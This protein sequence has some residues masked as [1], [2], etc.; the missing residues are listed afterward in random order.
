MEEK[1]FKFPTAFTI[2]F[3]LIVIVAGLT[4]VMKT[5]HYDFKDDK[6]TIV[7]AA[8]I[9]SHGTDGLTPVAGTYTELPGNPQ[10]I[11]DI[12]L[13]PIN[14]L[15]DAIDVAGFILVIG[16]FLAVAMS[17]GA[18]DTWIVS[19]MKDLKG[20]EKMLIPVLMFI[21][22][23]GG[24]T[25]GMSEETIAFYPILIPIMIAAGYDSITGVAV[26]LVG[27]TMGCLASTVNPFATGIASGFANVP[28]GQGMGMRL[29]TEFIGIAICSIFVMKY[30][31]AVKADP[32]KSLVYDQKE[33]NEKH[34]LSS[35]ADMNG[36]M[37]GKQRLTLYL[38]GL[39]FAVMIFGVIPFSDLGI[40]AVP[41]LGW[42]FPELTGL[43]L[44]A[45]IIIGIVNSI[46]EEKFVN[47]FVDGAK[48]L[49]SVALIVGV[50][51][52][53][54]VI[55]NKGLITD[56]VLDFAE[57]AVSGL[58]AVVF[59]NAVYIL[60]ILLSFFIPSTSGLATVSMPIMAPIADFS[61]VG[62]ELV[63]S[64]YQ[65]ASGIVNFITPT[66]GVVIGALTIGRISYDK[67]L[68]FMMPLILIMLVFNM[69]I[70][71]ISTML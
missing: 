9:E 29:A 33:E 6:G 56:T 31:E 46:D 7:K 14:G 44:V 34:F 5:G 28:L 47:T 64:A 71:S 67:W 19:I 59:V 1:K 16:G 22:S 61:H 50:A 37:T 24:S 30:A 65:Y 21:F 36:E 52:G 63:V 55:M 13:A 40:T 43:F 35:N 57:H 27:A 66:S 39:S 23:I 54:T 49:L 18:I 26:I 11:Y 10:G 20:R 8:D 58:S 25:Y 69:V 53:I 48:D 51:R 4:W 12:I 42:W 38:F 68:K 2:L 41:T 45:S 17:T 62:R 60:H 32:T 70:L 3:A 15:Y